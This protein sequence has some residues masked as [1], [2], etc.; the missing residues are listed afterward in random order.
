[1]TQEIE[2]TLTVE[3]NAEL[4]KGDITFLFKSIL[5]NADLSGEI[6][7]IKEESEIYGIDIE[8]A[9]S[10]IT[11]AM[12]ESMEHSEERFLNEN[13]TLYKYGEDD[14]LVIVE[15]DE[16]QEKFQILL[17]GDKIVFEVL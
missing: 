15:N 10:L 9:K 8:H 1:M 16:W 17:D 2:I 12:V 7:A 5:E 13:Y 4:S 14:I 11:V 3:V 6:K